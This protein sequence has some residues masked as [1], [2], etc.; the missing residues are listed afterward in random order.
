MT[1]KMCLYL[2]PQSAILRYHTIDFHV[3]ADI[4][5]NSNWRQFRNYTVVLLILRR[6]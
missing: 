4:N 3:Y 2:L 1:F 5:V 6:G